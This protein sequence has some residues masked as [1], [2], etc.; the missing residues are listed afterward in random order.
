MMINYDRNLILLYIIYYLHRSTS[1]EDIMIVNSNNHDHHHQNSSTNTMSYISTNEFHPVLRPLSSPQSNNNNNN[2]NNNYINNSNSNINNSSIMRKDF[3]LTPER[4]TRVSAVTSTISTPTTTIASSTTTTNSIIRHK[5]SSPLTIIS[6]STNINNDDNSSFNNMKGNGVIFPD[7]HNKNEFTSNTNNNGNKVNRDLNNYHDQNSSVYSKSESSHGNRIMSMN[8][9]LIFPSEGSL[10]EHSSILS[11]FDNNNNHDNDEDNDLSRICSPLTTKVDVPSLSI[12]SPRHITTTNS[13]PATTNMT[14][15]S[16][17]MNYDSNCSFIDL[18]NT[19]T[20]INNSNNSSSSS[21]SR[22]AY[23]KDQWKLRP[24]VATL[25]K[26]NNNHHHHANNRNNNYSTTTTNGSSSAYKQNNNLLS[27]SPPNNSNMNTISNRRMK[28]IRKF[29][30]S[31]GSH[32]DNGNSAN[33]LKDPQN[34]WYRDYKDLS[35]LGNN[36][37]MMMIMIMEVVMTILHMLQDILR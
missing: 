22:S 7:I 5:Q 30:F 24:S 32:H 11:D 14:I 35:K 9:D 25:I 16:S 23:A 1:F 15:I 28:T 13:T 6:S 8:N 21:S 2:N 3:V 36:M 20:V 31:N 33:H 12:L 19:T 29:N 10:L 4:T 27:P 37:I 34:L 18:P 26:A 17:V